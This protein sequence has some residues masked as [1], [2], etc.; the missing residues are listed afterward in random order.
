[1]NFRKY[2]PGQEQAHEV[3]VSRI[4]QIVQLASMTREELE[5]SLGDRYTAIVLPTRYGK[6]DVIRCTAIDLYRTEHISAALVL[7]PNRLL[8][9]QIIDPPKFAEM[10]QRYQIGGAGSL[11]CRSL[12]GK[13]AD[14][15]NP[16]E[17][18]E[19]L[20]SA[21]IQLIENSA[22]DYADWVESMLYRHHAPVLIYVDEAHTGSEAN[23]WGSVVE[24]LARRGACVCLLTATPMRSDGRRISGFQFEMM[25][26]DEDVTIYRPRTHEDPAKVNIDVYDGVK[27]RLRLIAHHT[28]TFK[29]AWAERPS[30]LCRIS[31]LPFDIEGHDLGLP[32]SL[33][34]LSPSVVRQ[35]LGRITKALSVMRAGVQAFVQQLHQLRNLESDVAGIVFVGNDDD[36][37]QRTNEHANQ[38][39]GLIEELD[40]SLDVVIATSSD[41]NAGIDKIQRFGRGRGDVLI[42]KQMASLGLDIGRLKVA[43]DL[44]PIRTP[45]AYIQRIMRIATPYRRA[46]VCVLIGPDDCLNRQLFEILVREEGGEATTVDLHFNKTYVK[47]REDSEA[48][49]L[50]AIGDVVDADFDDSLGIKAAAMLRPDVDALVAAVPELLSVL[51]HAQL[52]TRLAT[53]NLTFGQ[54][55]AAVVNTTVVADDLRGDINNLAKE[56]IKRRVGQPYSAERWRA[57]SRDLFVEVYRSVGVRPGYTLDTIDD[58]S[59]LKQIKVAFERIVQAQES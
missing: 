24:T 10:I 1:M 19:F 27:R 46:E 21:T 17:N 38:V 8:R 56:E 59:V 32:T 42:V 45:A 48:R 44:S 16:T 29:Q 4:R 13:A 52:G 35:N 25:G 9:D 53:S 41:G 34:K 14:L 28:T 47:D 43:L 18:G 23:E 54:R 31:R 40:S 6:S 11:R 22:R 58:L 15:M 37:L 5:A 39:R 12:D 3:V 49:S 50:F 55:S 2:R 20:L 26:D 7:S 33:S 36:R 57:T 30:P 51:T